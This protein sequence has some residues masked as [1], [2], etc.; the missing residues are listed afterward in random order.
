MTKKI[1]VLGFAAIGILPLAASA[2]L[3]TG[4]LNFV[5]AATIS[6]GSI[7]FDN[8]NVFSINPANTQQG[9]FMALGG[10]TG[11]ID[12]ITNPPDATGVLAV[13][14]TDFIT[15]AAAPNISITLT[16][17]LPGV[18]G[19]AGCTANP[20]AAGQLCTP[21]TPEE[22]PFNL[23]N[24]SAT[25]STA[26]FDILGFEVDSLTGDTIPIT[27]TFSQPFTNMNFQQLLAVVDGAPPP[28]GGSITTSFSG[29][30]ATLNAT[31]EPATFLEFLMGIGAL[32][33]YLNR[34]RQ[35][36]KN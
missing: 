24:T 14:V 18:D 9:G 12:N 13:P 6:F 7:T 2:S 22:S 1:L 23:Q 3:I 19:A 4:E 21:N 25:S 35:R 26:S 28:V 20:P 29:Q 31:P 8:G 11:S 15:F 33:I 10:T 5:G 34:S 27:G 36:A 30:I 17:L 16:D 32:G